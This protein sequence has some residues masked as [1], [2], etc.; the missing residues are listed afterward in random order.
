M[1]Y[2][3]YLLNIGINI[4][5]LLIRKIIILKIFNVVNVNYLM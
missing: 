2:R 5:V 1:Y 3:M 4:K